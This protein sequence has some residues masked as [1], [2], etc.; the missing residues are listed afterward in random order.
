M[1]RLAAIFLATL[2]LSLAGLAHA[3]TGPARQRLD[4]FATGLHSLKG[5]FTQTLADASGQGA[6]S[7]SG[8]L[9]LQAPREFRWDTLKPYKQTIVADGSRVWL[10]DPELE[11]VTVRKQSTEEAHSPLTVITDL[12]QL[13]RD[14]T[15]AEQGERDGLAWLRLT[16]KAKDPQFGYADLGFDAKGLRR[17]VFQ[18][19]LGAITDIR[20]SDW[21]R[22]LDLP[23]STFNF[24]P[25]PGADVIGDLPVMTTQPLKD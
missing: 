3:A 24:V 21:Q 12:K 5:N 22:N 9:A 6:K 17:M 18:D 14:F 4:A 13:D 2:A 20:F 15:V 25:P 10:Y 8:T 7:S 16:S 23:A 19:Q 1:N 11:Q